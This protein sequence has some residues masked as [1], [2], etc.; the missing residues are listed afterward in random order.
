[1][2]NKY[3]EL[4]E[5][6]KSNQWVNKDN[7]KTPKDENIKRPKPVKDYNKDSLIYLPDY[8]NLDFSNLSIIE[9]IK[10]RKSRRKY[11]NN[12]LS[13]TEL[14]FLLWATQGLR[15]DHIRLRT[16]P[17]G[18]AVHPFETYIYINRVDGIKP[19]LYRY[20]PGE[21]ALIF[22]KIIKNAKSKIIKAANNQKF[23]GDAAVV[24]MWTVLPKR[25]EWKYGILS[26]KLA[27]IDVGHLCQNLYIGTEAIDAGMCA[28]DA[29]DQK[30]VDKLLEID[31]QEEFVI[32]M[33]PVGKYDK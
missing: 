27:A 24:F 22:I 21:H 26:H 2:S 1:M 19:G 33:A 30:S 7:L 17:S 13:L 23:V 32:Y 5:F 10:N 16:V 31:G 4:R 11:N 15:D 9:I 29:Y 12:K 28:V 20:I 25:G 3:Q 8:N 6:L 14:S 18:G